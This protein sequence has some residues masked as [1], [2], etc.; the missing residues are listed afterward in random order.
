M[1]GNGAIPGLDGGHCA[2]NI[3][4]DRHYNVL[5]FLSLHVISEIFFVE[6]VLKVEVVFVVG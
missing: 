3:S 5:Q 6:Q 1:D 4:E 2:C